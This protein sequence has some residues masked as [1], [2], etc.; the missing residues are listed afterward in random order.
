MTLLVI[1]MVSG[2]DNEE[3]PSRA[4]YTPLLLLLCGHSIWNSVFDSGKGLKWLELTTYNKVDCS[5]LFGKLVNS[6]RKLVNFNHSLYFRNFM[7]HG[8]LD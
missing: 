8:G 6:S 3:I 2:T 1:I 5:S 4:D 7:S